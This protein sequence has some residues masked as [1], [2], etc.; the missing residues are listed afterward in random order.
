MKN[1]RLVPFFQERQTALNHSLPLETY[2]LKPVQRILK[3]HLLL[4]VRPGYCSQ[5]LQYHLLLQ[6]L[7]YHLLL[8]VRPGYCSQYLQ[9]PLLL[10]ELS[11]HFDKS[12][13]EYEVIEDAIIT[14]TAVA[15]YI[16]DM[17]RKQ[18]HA[19]RLQVPSYCCV[20]VLCIYIYI[21]T[22]TV[23]SLHEALQGGVSSLKV[24]RLTSRC[25]TAK[26]PHSTDLTRFMTHDTL[27]PG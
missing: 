13:P 12:D 5:Y 14:M 20:C 22:H 26:R 6:Y 25:Q 2:L 7:Q 21:Y 23:H 4:Q 3:Y 17:K 16:N 11:K 1:Q 18:E 8:Q 9:C 19:V 24:G 27:S 15:W 10:Q